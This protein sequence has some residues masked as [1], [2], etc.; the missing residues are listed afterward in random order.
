ME[1][2]IPKRAELDD[3]VQYGSSNRASSPQKAMEE[4]HKQ[5]THNLYCPKC[6]LNITKTA[7]LLEKT[8]ESSP[9]NQK[10]F[11]RWIPLVISFKFFSNSH[12]GP[13]ERTLSNPN[14]S[15]E[16]K[17][18]NPNSNG[19]DTNVSSNPDSDGPVDN[20]SKPYSSG[21]IDN[22]ISSN[23]NSKGPIENNSPDLHSSGSVKNYNYSSLSGLG[24]I[25]NNYS[26]NPISFFRVLV[27]ERYVAHFL[28]RLPTL[29]RNSIIRREEKNANDN[30]AD[31]QS[32]TSTEEESEKHKHENTHGGGWV[33]H[34]YQIP[35][36]NNDNKT[37]K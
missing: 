21:P 9:D 28:E 32:S 5:K 16:K 27:L 23:P 33:Y 13:V 26:I 3:D 8:D 12:T 14:K 29:C 24:T 31:H 11:V 30:S 35:N 17:S 7:Q 15:V 1:S 6:T 37:A 10:S 34:S 4:I 2:T 20:S 25:E 22:M 19:P 18:S 36:N